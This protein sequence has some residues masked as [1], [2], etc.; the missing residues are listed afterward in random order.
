[1]SFRVPFMVCLVTLLFPALTLAKGSQCYNHCTKDLPASIVPP[2]EEAVIRFTPE[3]GVT[4]QLGCSNENKITWDTSMNQYCDESY[5]YWKANRYAT[6][7]PSVESGENATYPNGTVSTG[8]PMP[9]YFSPQP[10]QDFDQHDDA[11]SVPC[12]RGNDFG[13]ETL[14]FLDAANLCSKSLDTL[15]ADDDGGRLP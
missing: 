7:A 13:S 2:V 1:M 3:V 14:Q 5:N 12:V 4:C 10:S 6:L 9:V 11:K 8:H 15:L